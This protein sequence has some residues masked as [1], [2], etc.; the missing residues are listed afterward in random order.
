MSYTD[1]FENFG[2]KSPRE[3]GALLRQWSLDHEDANYHE[4]VVPLE[5][6]AERVEALSTPIQFFVMRAPELF[7]QPLAEFYIDTT[8]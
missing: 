3:V 1:Q 4:Y 8:L 7:G 5:A 6:L 2:R